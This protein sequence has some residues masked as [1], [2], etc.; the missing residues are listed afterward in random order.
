MKTIESSQLSAT[1]M[2]TTMSFDWFEIFKLLV[3]DNVAPQ[4]ETFRFIV[5]LKAIFDLDMIQSSLDS[6]DI[7]EAYDL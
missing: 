2:Y 1:E 4:T 7:V 6:F 5:S 3:S